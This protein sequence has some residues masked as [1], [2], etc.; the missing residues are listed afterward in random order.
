M[1]VQPYQQ[2]IEPP[3]TEQL[4]MNVGSI[5]EGLSNLCKS[6]LLFLKNAQTLDDDERG[7]RDWGTTAPDVK[8]DSDGTTK[9]AMAIG[10]SSAGK[11]EQLKK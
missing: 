4:F 5:K 8:D 3:G 1:I 2:S 10:S 6:V 11:K 9:R 7:T